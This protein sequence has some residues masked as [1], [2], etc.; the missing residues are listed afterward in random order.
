MN[1]IDEDVRDVIANAMTEA[2]I[3]ARNLDV[4][5]NGDC[6]VVAGTVPNEDERVRLLALLETVAPGVGGVATR[7]GVL[8]RRSPLAR[9]RHVG[10]F[11]PR[12]PPPARRRVSSRP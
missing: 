12:E 9:H 6:A 3:D 2:G 10:R 1:R 4:E 5:V 11:P 8:R 7:V